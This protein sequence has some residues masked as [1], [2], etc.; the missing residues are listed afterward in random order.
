MIMMMIM[1]IL[2]WIKY[3]DNNSTDSNDNNNSNDDDNDNSNNNNDDDNDD[4][5]YDNDTKPLILLLQLLTSF[6]LSITAPLS[7]KNIATSNLPLAAAK[8]SGVHPPY[9][10]Y[11]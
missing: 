4:N 11:A 1:M 10:R 3:N 9:E 7:T 2:V 6:L 8:C 5:I